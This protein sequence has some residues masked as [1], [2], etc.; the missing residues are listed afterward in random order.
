[1]EY[2]VKPVLNEGD[3]KP[4]DIHEVIRSVNNVYKEGDPRPKLKLCLNGNHE[5]IFLY[6]TGAMVTLI[7]ASFQH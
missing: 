1:M 7:K 6:D 3:L 2:D 5:E 4:E